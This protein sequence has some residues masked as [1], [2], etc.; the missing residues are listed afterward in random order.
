VRVRA[1]LTREHPGVVDEDA[2][3]SSPKRPP[4]KELA[5]GDIP[6]S[7]EDEEGWSMARGVA[8]TIVCSLSS[9]HSRLWVCDCTAEWGL[10]KLKRHWASVRLTD[11]QKTLVPLIAIN[12][13]V[14][15]AWRI[16]S[17]RYHRQ[18]NSCRRSCEPGMMLM[19]MLMYSFTFVTG[20]VSS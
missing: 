19:L 8:H 12:S 5:P 2:A 10:E 1:G 17:P 20:C 9:P 18:C 11:A 14:F 6:R 13:L 4:R 16:P 15:L 3:D 7:L